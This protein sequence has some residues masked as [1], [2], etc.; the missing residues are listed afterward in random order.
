MEL[1][2]IVRIMEIGSG[3]LTGTRGEGNID[4]NI[5]RTRLEDS[6]FVMFVT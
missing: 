1:R 5:I 6:F 2:P 4:W 3:L